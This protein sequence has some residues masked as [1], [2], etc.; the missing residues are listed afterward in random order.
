MR[1]KDLVCA[2]LDGPGIAVLS[3]TPNSC[4]GVIARLCHVGLPK[5]HPFPKQTGGEVP[6]T[7]HVVLWND[8]A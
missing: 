5:L 6:L 7:Q 8:N 2:F 4:L 3:L 1:S